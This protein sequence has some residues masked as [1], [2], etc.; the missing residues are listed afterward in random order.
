[1]SPE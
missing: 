1:M